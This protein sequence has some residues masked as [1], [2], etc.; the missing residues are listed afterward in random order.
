M[1][2]CWVLYTHSLTVSL[3]GPWPPSYGSGIWGQ[4]DH[5]PEHSVFSGGAWIPIHLDPMQESHNTP[6]SAACLLILSFL[7]TRLFLPARK[8]RF[9]VCLFVFGL[10]FFLFLF[11]LSLSFSSGSFPGSSQVYMS[12][13][14]H[15]PWPH[16]SIC[17]NCSF[18]VTFWSGWRRR[19]SSENSQLLVAPASHTPICPHTACQ[20]P[21]AWV[22]A[23]KVSKN[24]NILSQR[25]GS[26]VL[27]NSVA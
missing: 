8:G 24:G 26:P 11:F 13:S 7:C 14:S 5:L 16:S 15:L 19:L 20:A 4:W 17:W 6:H 27:L 21:G 1:A 9:S 2:T 10:V 18:L 23:L 25:Q 22:L 3:W 12:P